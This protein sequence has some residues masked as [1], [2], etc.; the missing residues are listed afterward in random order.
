M[1]KLKA[2]IVAVGLTS[3]GAVSAAEVDHTHCKDPGRIYVQKMGMIDEAILQDHITQ[4]EERIQK[5]RRTQA[6]SS[7]HRKQLEMHMA[8]MQRAMKTMH[9]GVDDEA[10]L[11]Q[12][13][14]VSAEE[15]VRAMEKRMQSMQKMLDQMKKHQEEMEK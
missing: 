11:Q 5:A 9:E 7:Q 4:M 6:R 2:A 8:D 10:C 15:R 3:F 1:N 13:Q 12:S 14:D